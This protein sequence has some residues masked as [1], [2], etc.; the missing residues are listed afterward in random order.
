M[1][2][3]LKEHL[4][5]ASQTFLATFLSVLGATLAQGDIVW[6]GAFWSGVILV[7]V[8]AGIKELIAR[9]ATPTFGGRR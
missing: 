3:I 5:S 6:T 4:I 7:A 8:R 9:F 2:P 1:N